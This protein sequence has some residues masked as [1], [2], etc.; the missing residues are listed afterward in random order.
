MT[1]KRCFR[2]LF[3]LILLLSAAAVQAQTTPAPAA[4]AAPA[5]AP[6]PQALA[7]AKQVIQILR[8]QVV[9]QQ[10]VMSLVQQIARQI[11]TANKGK[12]KVITE[13]AQTSLLPA[14]KARQ[15]ALEQQQAV[16][17]AT[18]FTD[19]ELRQI[20]A[21]YKGPAG[22]KLLSTGPVISKD[23]LQYANV[24]AAQVFN[25]IKPQIPPEL[26]KRGLVVPPPPK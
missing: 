1:L 25:E 19:D 10:I 13:Y 2:S 18:R 4:P 14:V 17:V 9:P 22:A 3:L 21:F 12:E 23:M 5:A 24:W 11:L 7:D 8:L 20:I 26:K 6:N 15:A 16:I